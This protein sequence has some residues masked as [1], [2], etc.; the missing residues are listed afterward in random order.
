[1]AL[2][3]KLQNDLRQFQRLQQELGLLSQQRAQFEL[4]LRETNR[5][6]DELKSLPEDTPIYRTVGGLLVKSK[7]R[8]EVEDILIEDKE[9]L[10]VRIKAIERQE[11]HLRDKYETLQ[12]ELT[13]ALQAAGITDDSVAPPADGTKG[14]E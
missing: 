7:G 2:P 9:T 6:S 8:K 14:E 4:K 11:S 13:T 10:E 12:K 5:T 3:A 1:M